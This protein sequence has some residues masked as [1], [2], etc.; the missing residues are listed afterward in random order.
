LSSW[1]SRAAELLR[2]L[3]LESIRKK[4]LAFA[5][6]ATLIPSVSTAWISYHQNREALT[7]KITETLRASSGQT[8]RE[9]DIWLK[10]RLLDLRVF[11]S[12][13]EVSENLERAAGRTSSATPRLQNYL[14][15]VRGRFTDYTRLTAVDPTGRLIAGSEPRAPQPDLPPEWQADLRT[16]TH[17]LGPIRPDTVPGRELL[18]AVVPIVS[19]SG[20]MLGALAATLDLAPVTATLQRA[21]TAGAERVL[22]VDR[23]GRALLTPGRAHERSEAR[24]PAASVTAL[25]EPGA[26]AIEY[27]SLGEVKVLGMVTA[28]SGTPWMVVAELPASVAYARIRAQRN[29][30]VLAVSTLL[31]GVGLLAYFLGLLIVRPLN[32]LTEGADQVA[33]GDLEV[34][35][36]ITGS[37]E[38]ARLTGVFNHMVDKLKE[39]RT[40]LERLSLTDG[41][42][43]LYNRRHLATTIAEELARAR[44]QGR[45]CALAMLDVDHFKKYNDA[46]GHLAGDEVLV[47]VAKVIRDCTRVIDRPV[48]YG[49]EEML[50]LLP[51]TD[52]AGAAEVGERIRARLAEEFF[53]GGRVTVSVGVAVY[54]EHGESPEALIMSADAALYEAKHN[55]RD[56]V[57]KAAAVRAEPAAG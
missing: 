52:L 57:V 9:I 50:V 35:L 37:D 39:S 17:S 40:E 33:A 51:D 31:A 18:D 53:A 2:A 55:G 46:H 36:P 42:T 34:D 28:I 7:E 41:L 49:G 22:L 3:R 56:R 6:L 38:V 5:I 30:T 14:R 13:Y 47:R 29:M 48:R 19:A 15:S 8:A 43:G 27:E 44:R 12:S 23:E 24:L 54:P 11:A 26:G 21:T 25:Q 4:I 1:E 45:P 16:G 10:E 32:R 20:R